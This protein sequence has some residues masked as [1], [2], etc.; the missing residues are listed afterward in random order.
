MS[1]TIRFASQFN[2]EIARVYVLD[3]IRNGEY[4]ALDISD[5]E[6]ALIEL[7]YGGCW[8]LEDVNVTLLFGCDGMY[9][10][11]TN[12]YAQSLAFGSAADVRECEQT[13]GRY[14]SL[15]RSFRERRRL[16]RSA[17]RR[18]RR[19][20][21]QD[22]LPAPRVQAND[23]QDSRAEDPAEQNDELP[24]DLLALL[25]E[26]LHRRDARRLQA[27]VDA[28]WN[29][30]VAAESLGSGPQCHFTINLKIAMCIIAT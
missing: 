4:G 25:M 16:A 21:H 29:Y 17:E 19:Q 30:A 2:G 20:S 27:M 26:H 18:E 12:E 6:G 3:I 23:Q 15:L 14:F 9:A 11:L 10:D 28:D 13:L 5:R 8:A 7:R 1:A 22:F 24:N